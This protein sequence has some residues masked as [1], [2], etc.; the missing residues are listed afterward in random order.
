MSD[1]ARGV[2]AEGAA[3]RRADGGDC[4]ARRPAVR[5]RHRGHRRR[6][7]LHQ[8]GLRPRQLRPGAGRRRGA[9][10]RRR[11]RRDRRAGRRHLRAAADDPARRRGLHRRR[12]GQRRRAERRRAG[13]RPRRDRRR[14]RARLGRRP[15]L[16]LRGGA[17]GEPRPPGQLLPARGDDRHPRRLPGRARLQRAAKAGAGCSGSAACRRW[18]SPSGCCGCR[19]A[20]AGW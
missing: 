8:A 15:G 11:R 2:P 1:R 7:A 14:D 13:H 4:G 3:Q 17:A 5:L 10:R 18:R 12:A 19:R 6:P 20:R 9:D 16:H